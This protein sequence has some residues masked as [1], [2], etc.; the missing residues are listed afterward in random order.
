LP[1]VTGKFAFYF[2]ICLLQFVLMILVGIY[3]M[4]LLGLK[5]L[6]LGSNVS[7]I[8]ITACSV[9]IAATGYGTLI[10]V[11]FKTPQQ[12]LS[13]GSISVVILSALGGVWVPVYVM[14]E[15]LQQISRFSPLNWGLESFNDLFLRDAETLLILPNLLKLIIFGAMTLTA[16]ILINK[17]RTVS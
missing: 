10:A 6:I 16:S 9:A 1:V 15:I 17:S 13:F 14:P 3:G 8:I 4:P 12:A 11:Y 2:G 7:G 5:A